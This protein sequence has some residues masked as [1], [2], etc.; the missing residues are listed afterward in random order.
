MWNIHYCDVNRHFHYFQYSGNDTVCDINMLH[1]ADYSNLS[2]ANFKKTMK[3]RKEKD[4]LLK[5]TMRSI[6]FLISGI[7][8]NI[9]FL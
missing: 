4:A 3:E 9:L 6:R 8:L 2:L 5:K 7:Y 1:A